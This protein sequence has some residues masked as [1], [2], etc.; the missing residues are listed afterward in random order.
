M[1]LRDWLGLMNLATVLGATVF[2]WRVVERTGDL[3]RADLAAWESRIT[4][5]LDKLQAATC[6]KIDR[7]IGGVDGG[8]AAPG[9]RFEELAARVDAVSDRL[10]ETR[11][12]VAAL[13]ACLAPP[14]HSAP[15]GDL[16]TRR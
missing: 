6:E 5:H 12:D 11:E 15:S 1:E 13:K 9:E 10:E 3:A 2:I 7:F 8:C 16:L 14:I 4:A